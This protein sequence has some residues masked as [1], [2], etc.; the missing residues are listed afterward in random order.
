MSWLLWHMTGQAAHSFS[1]VTLGV[2]VLREDEDD[3]LMKA[4]QKEAALVA[5]EFS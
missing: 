1:Q 5:E 3:C 2:C 4:G